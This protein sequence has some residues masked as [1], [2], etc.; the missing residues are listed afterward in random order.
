M[1]GADLIRAERIRQIEVEGF[2]EANDKR[3]QPGELTMAA[4]CYSVMAASSEQMRG[5][6]REGMRTSGQWPWLP[7]WW[8]PGQHNSN[9]DRIYELTKAGALLAAEIDRLKAI[10]PMN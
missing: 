8:K 9:V 1:N 3:C 2:D 10:E 4:I 5:D 7:E 6:L